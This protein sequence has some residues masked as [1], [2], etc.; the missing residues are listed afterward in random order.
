[1]YEYSYV[2]L[3]T[4]LANRGTKVKIFFISSFDIFVTKPYLN[5]PITVLL[6]GPSGR[7]F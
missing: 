7:A 2:I 1:M 5:I 3:G 4:D 6:A